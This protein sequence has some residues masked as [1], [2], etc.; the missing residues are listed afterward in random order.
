MKYLLFLTARITW[1]N[2]CHVTTEETITF[3]LG[4]VTILTLP[5]VNV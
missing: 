5:V 1:V 3:N 2:D 4:L